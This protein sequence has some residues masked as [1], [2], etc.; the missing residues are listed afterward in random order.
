[1]AIDPIIITP[2]GGTTRAITGATPVVPPIFVGGGLGIP[3]ITKNPRQVVG[4]VPLTS[5]TATECRTWCECPYINKVFGRL[6]S[7]VAVTTSTYEND[8]SSFLVD[9]SMYTAN[10]TLATIT[11][12][13]Q[14]KTGATWSDVATLNNNVYGTN[15]PLNSITGHLMY[16]GYAINWGK[17]LQLQGEGIYRI[18]VTSAFGPFTGCL[19][20]EPFCLQ[21]W[22]CINADKTSKFEAT[23]TGKIGSIDIDGYLYDLCGMNWFDSI[24]IRGMLGF[25][26]TEYQEEMLQ[27][28]TGLMERERDEAIQTFKFVTTP[29]GLPKWLLDRF[30]VYGMMSDTLLGSDYCM[31]NS[32]YDMRQKLLV[33][34]GGFKPVYRVSSRNAKVTVEFAE[35]MRNVIK[36]KC[37]ES[38]IAT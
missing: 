18:K 37:C 34:A 12:I 35:G 22:N 4:F 16:A 30:K 20:S 25:E 29:K 1:M 17:V 15:Y 24:R 9:Y 32:D 8:W 14:K 2:I 27:Y 7:G 38:R 10:P 21:E 33:K 31:N 36:T 6:V 5:C 3:L 19:V 11:Y 26:E 28:N 13:L 23:L